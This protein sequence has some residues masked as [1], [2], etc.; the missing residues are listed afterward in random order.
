MV[1]GKRLFASTFALLSGP[2]L[3]GFPAASHHAAIEPQQHS[4]IAYLTVSA[5]P[6]DRF[7]VQFP[8]V[9]HDDHQFLLGQENPPF[10]MDLITWR[11]TP[12]GWI[13][14]YRQPGVGSYSISITPH[15]DHIDMEWT[16][17]NLGEKQWTYVAAT[18]HVAFSEAPDFE[19]PTQERTFLRIGGKWVSINGTDRSDGR[20]STQWYIVKGHRASAM[21]GTRPHAKNSFGESSDMP[22]NSLTAVVSRDGQWVL[23]EA[24]EDAQYICLNAPV[25]IH[26]AAF[27]GDLAPQQQ[28][29]VRGEFYILHGTLDELLARYAND[30]GR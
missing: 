7:L 15:G 12:N 30:F 10:R 17:Q 13:T 27:F 4:N 9:V 29:R 23:G 26:P 20:R 25:C 18:P 2:L 16:V 1:T 19:D 6:Q 14:A 24:F 22:D 11:K 5:L 8:E 21:M 3:S 28:H